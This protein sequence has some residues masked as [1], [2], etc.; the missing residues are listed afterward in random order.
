MK[1]SNIFSLNQY[2]RQRFGVAFLFLR[3]AGYPDFCFP[4]NNSEMVKLNT[5][6]FAVLTQFSSL[7]I[8]DGN[9]GLLGK[10]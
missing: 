5:V 3:T 8:F 6:E 10:I 9:L 7:L 4:A 2:K 1:H